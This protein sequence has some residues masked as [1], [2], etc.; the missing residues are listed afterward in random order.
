MNAKLI[1]LLIMAVFGSDKY[2]NAENGP[3]SGE[4]EGEIFVKIE[5]SE[6]DKVNA[7]I[8]LEAQLFKEKCQTFFEIF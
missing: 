1:L 4:T 5:E 6:Y 7:F 3:N 2:G 8:I